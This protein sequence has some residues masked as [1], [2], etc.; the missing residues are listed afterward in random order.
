MF[1]ASDLPSID[2]V[3]DDILQQAVICEITNRPFRIIKQELDFY[4]KYNLPLPRRHPDQRH[5]ERLQLR[6]PRK[7]RERL[8]AKC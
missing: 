6:N 7:L 4:R 8:C 1:Q 5:A 2:K 3:T